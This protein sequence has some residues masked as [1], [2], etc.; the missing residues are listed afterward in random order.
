VTG[1]VMLLFLA[2]DKVG[3]REMSSSHIMESIFNCMIYV[4]DDII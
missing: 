4:G 2:R 1:V 3:I